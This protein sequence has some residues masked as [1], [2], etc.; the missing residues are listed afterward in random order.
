MNLLF[1]AVLIIAVLV[2]EKASAHTKDQI[3][4]KMKFDRRCVEP[5]GV[6]HLDIKAENRSL[7][8]VMYMELSA[9]ADENIRPVSE[10]FQKHNTGN[11]MGRNTF[12]VSNWLGS[13]QAL[14]TEIDLSCDRRGRYALGNTYLTTGDFLGLQSGISALNCQSEI[15]V[16][17]RKDDTDVETALGGFLG[18]LSV[19]R[20]LFPDPV[21]F[22]GLSDYTGREPMKDISWSKSAARNKLT[23]YQYD[24]TAED[25]AC[26]LLNT[27]GA[28]EETCEHLFSLT[29][30]VLE[31][32]EQKHL[33]WSFYSNGNLYAQRF[34]ED[35]QGERHLESALMSLG[36]AAYG[37]AF[38]FEALI[39]RL[40]H[41]TL[42]AE[43]CIVITKDQT[44]I[45]SGLNRLQNRTG[46]RVQVLEAK[47]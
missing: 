16:Y 46:G 47:R 14:N 2:I 10:S 11:S 42:R 29:R 1:L 5:D 8:P 15:I 31:L 22:Q 34:S 32:L 36:G 18:N 4:V 45:Q 21:L 39:D 41:G 19:L 6:F 27:E 38:S 25:I 33:T 35:G 9:R 43:G 20:W 30:S 23:V 7:L 24:H 28:D 44:L 26:V 13:R 17:P 40:M 37:S 3:R 12:T